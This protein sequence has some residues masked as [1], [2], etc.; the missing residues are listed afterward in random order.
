MLMVTVYNLLAR[1]TLGVEEER[2]IV[3][4]SLDQLKR[5]GTRPGNI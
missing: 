1:R 2:H 3:N 4:R 5:Q